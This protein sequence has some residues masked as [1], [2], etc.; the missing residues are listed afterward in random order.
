MHKHRNTK[1]HLYL[2]TIRALATSQHTSAR[3]SEVSVRCTEAGHSTCV[4][5]CTTT[6]RPER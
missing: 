3:D 2:D 4:L 5:G 6:V 1:L